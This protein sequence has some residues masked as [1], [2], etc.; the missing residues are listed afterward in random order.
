V[1]ETIEPLTRLKYV[2]NL[3]FYREPS[4][5]MRVRFE[6]L[7]QI[8]DGVEEDS[9]NDSCDSDGNSIQEPGRGYHGN[10][11][12]VMTREQRKT[13]VEK[14]VEMLAKWRLVTKRRKTMNRKKAKDRRT[15]MSRRMVRRVLKQMRLTKPTTTVQ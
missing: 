13:M 4:L 12:A 10:K 14:M 9:A 5:G 3:E 2:R 8:P 1:D 15:M 7:S 6:K 11:T